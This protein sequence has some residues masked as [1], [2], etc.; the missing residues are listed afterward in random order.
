MRTDVKVGISIAVC[1]AIVAGVWYF[2]IRGHGKT[3]TEDLAAI[4]GAAR[5]AEDTNVIDF[6]VPAERTETTPP[7]PTEIEPGYREERDRTESVP[8]PARI[9]EVEVVRRETEP[10][11]PSRPPERAA[12]TTQIRP[13]VM[14]T[15]RVRRVP[16]PEPGRTYVVK[17]GDSFWS[18][19]ERQYGSGGLA[20]LIAQANPNVP[21]TKMRHGMTIVIPP[22]PLG[23]AAPAAS[24]SA[25]GTLETDAGFYT[26][27][28]GDKGFWGIAEAVYKH[29]RYYPLIQA[30]NPDVDPRKLKPGQRLLVPPKPEEP[31]ALVADV[32]PRPRGSGKSPAA[33]PAA[34]VR[35]RTGAPVTAVLPDGRVFD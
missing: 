2:L 12:D 3:V 28:D 17:A 18:I 16:E 29:G 19:A 31:A 14:D 26:V 1:L 4:E 7:A 27:K 8:P 33:T 15:T 11:L 30:A 5:R 20:G 32:S 22:K 21:P 25:A 6:S 24:G 10:I 34:R 35:V 9:E 13:P 23:G